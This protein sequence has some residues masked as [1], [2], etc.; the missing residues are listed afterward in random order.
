M[1][2]DSPIDEDV[3]GQSMLSPQRNQ[4]LDPLRSCRIQV[5]AFDSYFGTHDEKPVDQVEVQGLLIQTVAQVHYQTR[6]RSAG[7]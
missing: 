4:R 3:E 6:L 2:P 1:P 7:A 5:Q